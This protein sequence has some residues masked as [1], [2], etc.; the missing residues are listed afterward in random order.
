MSTTANR[1]PPG[2]PLPTLPPNPS[3]F[4]FFAQPVLFTPFYYWQGPDRRAERLTFLPPS[5]G[6][7]PRPK[8]CTHWVA[9]Y[10]SV[11]AAQLQK[12][13]RAGETGLSSQLSELTM[14]KLPPSRQSIPRSVMQPAP[15]R[16]IVQLSTIGGACGGFVLEGTSCE[17]SANI[18]SCGVRAHFVC[19]AIGLLTP[20]REK[21]ST[22]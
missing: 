16:A 20:M 14:K 15:A 9:W 21:K 10:E 4:F 12:G 11:R 13:H 17:P 19:I 2:I 22:P 5:F 8:L 18:E 6:G 7:C 3:T 1:L